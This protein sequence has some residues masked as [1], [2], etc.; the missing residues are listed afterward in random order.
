MH[1]DNCGADDGNSD[2]IEME[3]GGYR[4]GKMTMD[5]WMDIV[6][7]MIDRVMVRD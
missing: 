4:R 2:G 7:K 5:G 6:V 3:D 1:D